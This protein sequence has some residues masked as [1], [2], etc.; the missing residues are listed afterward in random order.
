M[1][2]A[3]STAILGAAALGAGVSMYG[4]SQAAKAQKNAARDAAAATSEAAQQ[5]IDA[6]ERMF[7]KQ[8]ELQ[9]P[10]RQ[11]GLSAQNRLMDY[12]A[13]SENKTAPGYG[14]YARDFS[15]ADYTAD[16]GYGFRVSEGMKALERSAA[17]R[18][19]LLSGSTLKGITR[20][21]QDTAS[22]EYQN[23]FNRYQVNRANQLNPLQSL[24]SSGQT[25][26]NALTSAAGQTGAGMGSTY[27]GMGAGL[28]N[29]AMAG[30]AAR[31]S[32]Y[33][34]MAN[35]L[36]SGLSTGAN[37]YMQYP[38]YQAMGQ[39]YSRPSYGQVSGANVGGPGGL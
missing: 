7:G 9:E 24:I 27:M 2:V 22:E 25:G 11:A 19:G 12:L 38:L 35:A 29:A 18:G 26:A 16:P 36:T 8:V 10:F 15:L 5:S 17:A 28:S 31:A 30:G 14:K 33:T 39:Y 37:L 23:A 13:L 32:G 20:F 6:Q 4:A 1:A 3:T 21:G 34:G